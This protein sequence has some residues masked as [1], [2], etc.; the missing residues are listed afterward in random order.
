MGNTEQL[1]NCHI[2]SRK[3]ASCD[4]KASLRLFSVLS[5]AVCSTFS[6]KL[7]L[8]AWAITRHSF[9]ATVFVESG[10]TLSDRSWGSHFTLYSS[11]SFYTSRRSSRTFIKNAAKC[12]TVP[13]A[14]KKG[15]GS[16]SLHKYMLRGNVKQPNNLCLILCGM[17]HESLFHY[18]MLIRKLYN[19]RNAGDPSSIIGYP[20]I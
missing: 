18:C 17:S 8:Q 3:F 7:M 20:S 14:F 12:T 15:F 19:S 4:I 2:F 1:F 11:H 10:L 9:C 16:L 6:R 13:D 5:T